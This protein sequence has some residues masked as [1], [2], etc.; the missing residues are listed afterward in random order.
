MSEIRSYRLLPREWKDKAQL[1]D[2]ADKLLR[3]RAELPG[4]ESIAIHLPFDAEDLSKGSGFWQLQFAGLVIPEVLI[5]AYRQTGREAYFSA[6]RDS[7]L[8]FGEYES[9]AWFDRGFLW[10]DHAV[11][12]R[13]R[14]LADFWAIY[15]G[16]PDYD[17]VMARAIWR[18]AMR[19]GRMLAKLDNFTFAT[20]HGVMQNL[21]LWHLCL[22]FPTLEDCGQNKQLAFRRLTDEIPFYIGP[23]GV[24]LEHSA[25]YHEFGVFLLGVALRY[26]TLL[27]VQVPEAW[28]T[29]Y[30]LGKEFY[31]QI[32]RPDG[33]L[34]MF[35]D[36]FN[37]PNPNGILLT[38]ETDEKG[39][40]PLKTAK[41]FRPGDKF[42]VYPIS[43]YA[44]QWDGLANWS[45]AESL[46]QTVLTSSYHPGHGHKH[47]DELS[48][49]L[50]AG[51]RN[52]WTNAGYW[53]YED[54]GRIH[55]EGWEGSN[56]PRLAG[57]TADSLRTSSVTGFAAGNKMTAVEMLRRGPGDFVA[58]RLAVH[59]SPDIWI[60]ADTFSGGGGK[61]IDTLW[62]TAPGILVA[63]GSSENDFVL[64]SASGLSLR[65]TFSGSPGIRVERY[66]GSQKP[67]A[68][69]IAGHDGPEPVDAFLT[70]QPTE[71]AFAFSIWRLDD[72]LGETTK[73]DSAIAPI[74]QRTGETSWSVRLQSR[75]SIIAVIR[76]GDE[77][78][79]IW[80]KSSSSA[81][82]NLT[83]THPA[84]Q[85]A[86]QEALL[87]SAYRTVAARY[88]RYRD[89]RA[90]RIRGTLILLILLLLQEF[91]LIALVSRSYK[92]GV[93]ARGLAVLSWI[94]VG[95]WFHW[96][97]LAAK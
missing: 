69:W 97:Y 76:K 52:W 86:K 48:V 60:I 33:S 36:T 42:K 57:E 83:L 1:V 63:S 54:F 93:L 18:F 67:F 28:K 61:S 91:G 87:E 34:P 44:V 27:N 14:T 31:R 82:E 50:W 73:Q 10:N 38:N 66:R 96:I 8:A 85:A 39:F 80:G 20:N 19:T 13:V 25:E 58:R 24:V 70:E 30:E 64:S 26:A 32:R 90:Y 77:I 71:G 53:S 47:A 72:Q 6:A 40:G 5:D 79:A 21:A 55:A 84:P 92:I 94:G 74:V 49:L 88:P 78:S 81:S 11:A 43:G 41:D 29:R 22:A 7:I 37:H 89:L 35:G 62:T 4:Y 68:G 17:P 45:A 2:V 3:G 9:S 75:S 59:V 23:D 65:S 15:R 51:G 95:V 56:A 46:S 16:R 12:A